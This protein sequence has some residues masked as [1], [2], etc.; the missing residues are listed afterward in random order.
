MV[1]EIACGKGF[2]TLH[3][4]SHYDAH[5]IGIDV[6]PIHIDIARRKARNQDIS[7][8]EFKQNDFHALTLEDNQF[9]CAF[10][11][12]SICHAI[13]LELALENIYR[14]LK[15][16][17]DFILFDCFKKRYDDLTQDEE[18]STRL[19]EKSMSV[20]C[21]QPLSNFRTIAESVGFE[22][23]ELTDI[24]DATMPNLVRFEHMAHRILRFPPFARLLKNY[25]PQHFTQNMIAGLLMPI[26]SQDDILGYFRIV[27]HR[28]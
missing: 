24:S 23:T 3:L 12:E 6:T 16:G 25:L 26:A 11:V 4:A 2:N 14:V 18:I 10:E 5:F 22:V 9:D 28:P 27:L 20:P 19:I 1:L 15:P 13:D 21:F 8:V 17:S 7:N